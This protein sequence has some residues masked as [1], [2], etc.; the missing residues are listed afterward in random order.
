MTLQAVGNL[1]YPFRVLESS[2]TRLL[3]ADGE[4][5]A[6][7]FV[8]QK[9][10]DIK[11]VHFRTATVTVSDTLKVAIQDI[12]LD[13]EPDG[14]DDIS[15]TISGLTSN[16][17]HTATFAGS[18]AVSPGSPGNR[19][20]VVFSFDSYVAGD[21]SLRV[22]TLGPNLGLTAYTLDDLSVGSWTSYIW[23]P[24]IG[25]EYD[26]TSFGP[27]LGCLAGLDGSESYDSADNPD[28]RGNRFLFPNPL[29]VA[30]AVFR[31]RN[32]NDDGDFDLVLY[33][34]GGSVVYPVTNRLFIG[35]EQWGGLFFTETDIAAN[36]EF[37]LAIKA[38]HA[39]QVITLKVRTFLSSAARNQEAF[40]L[41]CKYTSR[42]D[43]G[44]W[45]ETDTK[46]AL[47]YPVFSRFDDGVGGG[48]LRGILTG[49]RL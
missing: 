44:S 13:G 36:V 30:G 27:I 9:A 14:V 35:T 31:L 34:S 47:I 12:G 8:I 41:E 15:T 29:T 16:T 20:A 46:Q 42:V 7:A 48:G 25:I 17:W 2:R 19:K 28:E 10:G 24:I 49:G 38:Q 33:H 32:F 39:T 18:L 23:G 43:S 6:Q 5:L 26:D 45:S 37:R 4:L 40:G 3:D 21:L 1:L 11:K 22:N